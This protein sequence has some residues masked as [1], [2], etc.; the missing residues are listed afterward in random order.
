MPN[1]KDWPK[2]M[3]KDSILPPPFRKMLGRPKVCKR[4]D[5]NEP[6]KQKSNGSNL[7]RNGMIMTCT[8]WCK[9]WHNKR[10]CPLT[11]KEVII[12]IL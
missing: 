8:F 6:Q 11:S 5:P 12:V 7:S 4:K 1:K 3:T 2:S 9:E 10:G